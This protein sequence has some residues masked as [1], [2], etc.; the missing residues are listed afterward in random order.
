MQI[1]KMMDRKK[2]T[3]KEKMMAKKEIILVIYG[4]KEAP[5]ANMVQLNHQTR[6]NFVVNSTHCSKNG[7]ADVKGFSTGF[8]EIAKQKFINS[9]ICSGRDASN[10]YGLF[11]QNDIE[12]QHFVEKVQ[13]NF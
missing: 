10:V 2:C 5:Y 9:V 3:K 1:L 8:V 7:E 6:Q 12:S 11:Y 4:Q 13:Q